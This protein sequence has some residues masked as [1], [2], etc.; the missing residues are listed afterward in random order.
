MNRSEIEQLTDEIIG[1]AVLTLLKSHGPINTQALIVALGNM[2]ANE[3][4]SQRREAI[5]GVIA[6]VNNMSSRRGKKAQ[7]ADSNAE[8]RGNVL[9]LFGNR[10]PD[11]AKKMH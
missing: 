1:E 8:Q 7:K 9:Q 11:S 3:G 2:E 4:D 10:Q 5:K 6:E